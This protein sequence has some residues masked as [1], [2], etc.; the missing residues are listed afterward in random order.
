MNCDVTRITDLRMRPGTPPE[1]GMLTPP[2]LEPSTARVLAPKPAM[3]YARRALLN[4]YNLLMLTVVTVSSLI[5]GSIWVLVAGLVAELVVL[6]TVPRAG[7]FRKHVNGQIAQDEREAALRT[8][9]TLLLQM[10]DTHRQEYERLEC[11]VERVR[12]NAAH[13]GDAAALVL[14]DSL[15][16]DRLLMSYIR[17][18]IAHKVGKEALALT[19]RKE[20]FDKIQSLEDSR[21][22]SSSRRL[23]TLEERRLFIAQQRLKRCDRNRERLQVISQQLATINDLIHMVHEQSMTPV[24]SSQVTDEIDQLIL[25]IEEN[26]GTLRELSEICHDGD[27]LM[28]DDPARL[29]GPSRQPMLGGSRDDPRCVGMPR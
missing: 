10:N 1:S 11:L 7:A 23:R 14:N 27:A 24:D 6:G 3:T 28:D 26:E 8:R 22:T 19:N 4:Q 2:W 21:L 20:L 12:T 17:L 29:N 25:S 9:E 16:L 13:Y 18:A 15:G 5:S